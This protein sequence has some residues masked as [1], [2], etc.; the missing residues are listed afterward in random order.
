MSVADFQPATQQLI[1]KKLKPKTIAKKLGIA[2]DQTARITE[3]I[4]KSAHKQK[5]LRL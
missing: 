3:M 2:E 5:Y 4:D 1:D